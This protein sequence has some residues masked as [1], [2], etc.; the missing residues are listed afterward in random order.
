M[1]CRVFGLFV[2]TA[3]FV[4]VVAQTDAVFSGDRVIVAFGDSTTAPRGALVVYATVLE[5]SLATE[6]V[7]AKVV[8][9]GVRGNT[10]ADARI[11]LEKDVIAQNPNVAIVQFGINDAAV[12]VDKSPPATRARVSIK[13]YETNLRYFVTTLKDHG[14]TVILMTP[15]SCRWT[16]GLLKPL[17]KPPYR[18]NNPDGFNVLLKQYA[19]VVRQVARRERVTLIDVYQE[20]E[21]Y[22]RK[23]GQS[24]DDLLLDGMHPNAK[25][26]QLI[27]RLLLQQI[28][29]PTQN[30]HSSRTQNPTLQ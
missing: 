27:A 7:L 12:D 2:A 10:T 23:P 28:D 8:N 30:P 5:K 14:A 22:G 1:R 29:L 4:S 17:G 15:N 3:M 13:E 19:E 11:R 16:E 21:A 25:G 24:V 26:H 20:F 18:P 9:A 6:G